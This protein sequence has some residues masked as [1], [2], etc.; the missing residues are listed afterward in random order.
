MNLSANEMV[1]ITINAISA[2]LLYMLRTFDL[3]SVEALLGRTMILSP[4]RFLD[5][6]TK[7]KHAKGISFAEVLSLSSSEEDQVT[8]VL[9]AP[10]R[11]KQHLPDHEY[12]ALASN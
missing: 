9:K 6:R 7:V 4:H 2:R 10:W 11:M 5:L 3:N 12:N 8:P 1:S